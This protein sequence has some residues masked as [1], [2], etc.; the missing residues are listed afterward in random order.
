MLVYVIVNDVTLKLYIGKHKG[1]NLKKY[2]Q[3]KISDALHYQGGSSHLFAAI[4]KHGREHF[5]VY[6]LF[7]GKTNE[8]ICVHETLLI[9]AL[10]AQNPEVG[11][12]IC[13]G[14]EGFTGP[15]TAASRFK[16]AKN[17]KGKQ[18]SL[19]TTRTM[20]PERIEALRQ[21][22]TGRKAS[23][24]TIQKLRDSHTGLSRS[25]ASRI[26]QGQTVSGI[27]NHFYGETHSK[28]TRAKMREKRATV[29]YH[30]STHGTPIASPHTKCLLC[31]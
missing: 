24:E 9:K 5:H 30:C 17:M 19:G 16:I 21:F 31:K 20:S 29:Q 26:K 10:A 11:Y 3:T 1:N 23:P 27:N 8:E 22:R 4:R 2:F 14:G 18:N 25:K 6:P 13:R 7:E 15:H 28:A 12:N